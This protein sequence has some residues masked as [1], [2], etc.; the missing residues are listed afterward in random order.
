MGVIKGQHFKTVVMAKIEVF[1]RE[2]DNPLEKDGSLKPNE[3]LGIFEIQQVITEG[4][5]TS[6]K[7]NLCYV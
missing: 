7:I 3:S 4:V 6:Q 1:K 5:Y 2:Y